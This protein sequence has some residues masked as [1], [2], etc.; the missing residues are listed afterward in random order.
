MG[1]APKEVAILA[2]V[3]G[4]EEKKGQSST[5]SYN[6]LID[7]NSSSLSTLDKS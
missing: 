7:T 5:A 1:N 4:G 2:E 3:G 6:S